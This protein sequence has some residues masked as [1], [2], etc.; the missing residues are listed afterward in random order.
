LKLGNVLEVPLKREVKALLP[1][2]EGRGNRN[3]ARG[4]RSSNQRGGKT[5][6]QK[7]MVERRAEKA[8][9]TE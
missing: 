8:S 7:S 5:K 6:Q 9:S 1:K 2:E 4:H 3:G